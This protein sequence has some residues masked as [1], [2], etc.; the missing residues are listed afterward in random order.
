VITINKPYS[1]K[2]KIK[3][4][5]KPESARKLEIGKLNEA[6]NQNRQAGRNHTTPEE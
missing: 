3:K 2:I 4:Q 5:N 6:R 1:L